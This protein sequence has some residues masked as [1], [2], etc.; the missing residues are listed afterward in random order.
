MRQFFQLLLTK[1][2]P[3]LIITVFLAGEVLAAIAVMP[4]IAMMMLMLMHAVVVLS[5]LS[6]LTL[7]CPRRI[8]A[9][10]RPSAHSSRI[11]KGF[12]KDSQSKD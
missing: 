11:T 5:A 9:L 8:F 7:A 10:F 6:S 1:T 3:A 2:I 12:C 4:R